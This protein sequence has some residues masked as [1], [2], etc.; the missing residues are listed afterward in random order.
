MEK[1]SDP[2]VIG[3]VVAP[4]GVRGTVRVTGTG[5]HLREGVEPLV[6]GRR[7]RI[8]RVRPTPKGFLVDL[9]GVTGRAEAAALK[10]KELLLDRRE[11][12]EPGEDEYYAEDLV[13]LQVVNHAGDGVGTVREVFET[14]A[15]EV[16]VVE[17]GSGEEWYL[18][19][20]HEHVSDVDIAARRLVARPPG[21]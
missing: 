15:H 7:T 21:S 3:V 6:D 14:P 10:N 13:G 16:L 2:I 19:F 1:L 18:P 11:L 5:R 12:D 9:E 8:N 4:H 17:A 20:T